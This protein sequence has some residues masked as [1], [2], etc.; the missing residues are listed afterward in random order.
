MYNTGGGLEGAEGSHKSFIENLGSIGRVAYGIH[1]NGRLSL[2]RLI[3]FPYP[4]MEPF[5]PTMGSEPQGGG[6]DYGICDDRMGCPSC[7]SRIKVCLM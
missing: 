2:G 5:V 6:D 1:G 7:N 4:R 3:G